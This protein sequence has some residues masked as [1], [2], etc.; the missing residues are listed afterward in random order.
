[1]TMLRTVPGEGRRSL[2]I[3][4]KQIVIGDVGDADDQ[5]AHAAARAVNDAGGD[6]DN[7]AFADRMG[8]AVKR[9]RSFTLDRK[10]VV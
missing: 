10:S 9:D 5:H 7:R 4:K 6:V 8:L 3:R 1:M 2:L